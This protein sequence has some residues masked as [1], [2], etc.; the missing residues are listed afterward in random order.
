MTDCL[1]G[2]IEGLIR[3]ICLEKR[4]GNAEKCV[5]LY[6]EAINATTTEEYQKVF[7]YIHYAKL[8]ILKRPVLY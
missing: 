3:Y 4:T 5:S 2:H 8:G 7:L 1:P 6:E